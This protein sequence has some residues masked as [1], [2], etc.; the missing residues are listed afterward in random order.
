MAPAFASIQYDE[1]NSLN[2][3]SSVSPL[4]FDAPTQALLDDFSGMSVEDLNAYIHNLV[5]NYQTIN[6]TNIQPANTTPILVSA[7]LAASVIMVKVGFPCASKLVQYS[8]AGGNYIETNGIF[9][10]RLINGRNSSTPVEYYGIILQT[11]E[12]VGPMTSSEFE[13]WI[14]TLNPQTSPNWIQ[15]NQVPDLLARSEELGFSASE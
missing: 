4:V 2:I 8:I 6:K 1:S 9:A 13:V 7:W 5:N 10:Q 14:H 15:S 11:N 3:D 12:L